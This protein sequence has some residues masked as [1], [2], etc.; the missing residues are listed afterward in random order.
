MMGGHS[1][2][3]VHLVFGY[4]TISDLIC[5]VLECLYRVTIETD[6]VSLEEVYSRERNMVIISHIHLM[7]AQCPWSRVPSIISETPVPAILLRNPIRLH[8]IG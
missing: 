4:S 5:A 6:L 8:N 2:R 7:S 1:S 3:R